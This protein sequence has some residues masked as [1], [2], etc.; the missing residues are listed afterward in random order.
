MHLLSL[1]YF[2]RCFLSSS[3]S[4]WKLQECAHALSS[5]SA[6][7]A[8]Q[9]FNELVF[10]EQRA[11]KCDFDANQRSYS[12]RAMLPK[13]AH[14]EDILALQAKLVLS[15][16]QK[17]DALGLA[18]AKDHYA[19]MLY[20]F[21]HFSDALQLQQELV[22][23][24]K[25]GNSE[26][27]RQPYAFRI[28]DRT[29]ATLVKLERQHEA[30][31]LWENERSICEKAEDQSTIRYER[32]MVEMAWAYQSRGRNNEALEMQRNILSW[33]MK[34]RQNDAVAIARTED[35]IRVLRKK[36]VHK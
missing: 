31:Q 11:G 33:R 32:A 20:T 18:Q 3:L 26:F 5:S 21:G 28:V 16:K 22:E 34:H 17:S 36:L 7:V 14:E 6:L 35:K 29:A 10:V 4:L 24:F 8:L 25:Q 15:Q 30:L 23:D 19:S 2:L 27:S 13:K 9:L 12:L 1:L